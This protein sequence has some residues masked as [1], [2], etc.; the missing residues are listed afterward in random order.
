MTSDPDIEER[1]SAL[2]HELRNPLAVI[3]GYAEL[4]RLRDDERTRLEASERILAAVAQLSRTLDAAIDRF[5]PS[6]RPQPTGTVPR[7]ALVDDDEPLR[8]LLRATLVPSEYEVVESGSGDDALA[9]FARE[10]PDLVVL[11]W[12][13]PG[14]SGGEVLSELKSRRPDVPVI[15]LTAD[16]RAQ[17]PAADAF[18]LKPFSPIELLDLIERLLG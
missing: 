9:L 14:R 10:R 7:I 18:L 2:A 13:L 3:S 11:D 12:N 8:R 4:L 15:V 5:L 17:A 16:Q 1:R 6:D